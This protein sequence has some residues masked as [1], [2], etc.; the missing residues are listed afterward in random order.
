MGEEVID[1]F[2]LAFH[3]SVADFHAVDACERKRRHCVAFRPKYRQGFPCGQ[4][5]GELLSRVS[6]DI[7]FLFQQCDVLH[8]IS[9]VIFR[10]GVVHPAQ[11]SLRIDQPQGGDV[12]GIFGISLDHEIFSH[13]SVDL[14]RGT[15]QEL[16]FAVKPIVAR[17]ALHVFGKHFWGIV[18]RIQRKT[19]HGNVPLVPVPEVGPQKLFGDLGD[20][21]CIGAEEGGHPNLAH[22]LV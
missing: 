21:R 22:K 16:P 10:S 2:D 18:F 1:N 19:N 6:S 7:H 11:E 3:G 13:E 12:V 4:S 20:V 17:V 14:F 8:R 9:D 5:L 15:G